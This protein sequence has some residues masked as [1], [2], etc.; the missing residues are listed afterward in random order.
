VVGA[1]RA[2]LDDVAVGI[3]EVDRIDHAVVRRPAAF[4]ATS[5]PL[6][7]H[8]LQRFGLDL[9]GDVQVEVVL[10]LELERQVAGL[11]EGEVRAVVEAVEGVQR[12]RLAAG[13]GAPD[14][15]RVRQRQA[16]EILVER[17]RLLRVAAAVGVVV[18]LADHA[19]LH[20]HGR[21]TATIGRDL[22][23]SA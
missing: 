19:S 12:P 18:E 3:A 21:Q 1:L 15:E 5:A 7:Q 23:D 17:A 14:V 10:R 6:R 8:R 13:L 16:E 11:E 9:E 22:S 20:R 2:Q 4:D